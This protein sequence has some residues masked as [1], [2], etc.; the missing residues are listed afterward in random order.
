[1]STEPSTA[2]NSIS[3]PRDG[4]SASGLLASLPQGRVD[5]FVTSLSHNA[6]MALPWLFEHWAHAHQMPPDGDWDT[7]VIL[8]GRGAGKTRAGA[9]WVRSMVEGS[10]PLEAGK[11]RRV[12][13]IGA[14]YDQVRD[15]MIRGDSGILAVSPPDRRPTYHATRRELV[16]PNG[17]VAQVFSAGDPEALRGPQF[18][19][20]WADELAKWRRGSM[21]WEM[22]QLCLRLGDRPRAVVTT[23]P[24]DVKVL[25]DI[26]QDA[27]TVSSSAP[28]RA[29]RAYLARGF[30]DRVEALYGGSTLGRQELDG[31]LLEEREGAFWGRAGIDAIRLETAPA[32]D[33]IVVAVDPPVT[34]GAGADECGIVVVGAVTKGPP[35][36]WRAYVLADA[37]LKGPPAA[38][39]ARARDT[40]RDWRAD[41][42][43]AEINQG[44]DLVETLLRTVDAVVPYK[45]VH[46]SRGTQSRAEPVAALYEQGRVRHCG[47]V[48][49]LEDQMCAM[50]NAGYLGSGSPDRLDA[51]VWALTELVIE[52]SKMWQSPGIRSL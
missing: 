35:Q 19:A 37:S 33:R 45:G 27:G 41:R 30:V 28:T 47:V 32:L 39:I 1:M 50:T 24:R 4:K 29:N 31:E 46:A 15:V 26:L 5:E 48:P 20:V 43:I 21:T 14:T 42:I 38:W 23:T 52:P 2:P 51:L 16:W 40:F 9:E 3:T 25:K 8:G 6:L 22:V 13:L 17:A 7:W 34:S 18:D 11:A 49:Q 10:K 36:D 12:G 44:G